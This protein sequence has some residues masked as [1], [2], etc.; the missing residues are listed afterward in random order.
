MHK[1]FLVKVKMFH[2]TKCFGLLTINVFLIQSIRGCKLSIAHHT[3][4]V[5]STRSTTNVDLR[6]QI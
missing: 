1:S 6:L 5:Y 3:L 4:D 2:S